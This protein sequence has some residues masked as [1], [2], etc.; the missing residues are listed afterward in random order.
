[1][2]SLRSSCP[3]QSPAGAPI[4]KFSGKPKLIQSIE[5]SLPGH[6]TG[7]C[8][9]E[10][11]LK[12]QKQRYLEHQTHNI[13][14][15]DSELL[16]AKYMSK[17]CLRSFEEKIDHSFFPMSCPYLCVCIGMMI[18]VKLSLHIY[19]IRISGLGLR[20]IEFG[21]LGELLIYILI[22]NH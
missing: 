10:S 18:F 5:V 21:S 8:G 17:H 2:P 7:W 20:H 22:K 9:V 15:Y 16:A 19:S 12:A 6:I 13:L 14:V 11:S 1:M 3:L 4:G